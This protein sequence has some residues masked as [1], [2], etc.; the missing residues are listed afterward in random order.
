MRKFSSFCGHTKLHTRHYHNLQIDS[1]CKRSEYRLSR[2]LLQ[3]LILLISYGANSI[4]G[5][6]PKTKHCFAC[7]I[8]FI[9]LL[10]R[11]LLL[12]PYIHAPHTTRI[13]IQFVVFV[14]HKWSRRGK[15]IKY[16]VYCACVCA[17]L[18][19]V[20]LGVMTLHNKSVKSDRLVRS[21]A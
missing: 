8:L 18:K 1:F 21:C 9:Y 17:K 19:C 12:P 16:L 5:S 15:Q 14:F 11:V 3:S 13:H 4:N 10:F 20:V 2:C 6:T 7:I